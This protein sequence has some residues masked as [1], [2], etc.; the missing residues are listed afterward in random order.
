VAQLETA[1][2]AKITTDALAGLTAAAV[3][4]L[5]SDQVANLT[6]DQVKSLS[7]KQIAA[8]GTDDIAGLTTSQ[9]AVLT[10]A[11][12][13]ALTAKQVTALETADL[14]K[15][16]TDALAGL[17]AVGVAALTSDQI[18]NMTTDQIKSFSTVQIAAIQTADIAGL[19]TT[20]INNLTTTQVAAFTAAQ[21]KAMTTDQINKLMAVTPL[22]LDLDGNG[23]QTLNISAGVTFDLRGLGEKTAVG[24]I[25]PKDGLLAIDLNHD[26]QINDGRELFGSGTKLADGTNAVDGF[27][28][29]KAQDTNHDGVVDAKDAH[30]ADLR[31]WVDAN[32]DGISQANELH[33]L[34][35]LGIVK[36]NV[37]ADKVLEG[38]NGNAIGLTAGYV[39]SDGA[40]HELSDVWFQIGAAQNRV[41]D[42]TALD[43]AT[44]SSGNLGQ[45][46]LAGNGGAG[47]VLIVKAED[48]LKFGATDLVTNAQTGSGHVQMVIKGDANDTVKV[49]ESQGHWSDG[50]VTVVDGVTYHIYNH[51]DAQLLI[52]SNVHHDGV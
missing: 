37:N 4:A 49:L 5:T 40:T 51:G 48:V 52:G 22:A 28:A 6:T 30:F 18:Q 25:G 16:T 20:Q 24:W 46:N 14:A 32:Q 3:T 42:L 50:G 10:S 39:T 21:I 45:I 12:I 23:V 8:I 31:V 38:N 47:D 9:A 44:V 11:Q 34:K 1:D 29:L 27:E 41:I 17:T 15:I 19:T 43:T 35:E 2:L 26:G 36:L 7:V 13:G 33:T